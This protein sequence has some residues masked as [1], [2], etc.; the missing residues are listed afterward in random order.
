MRVIFRLIDGIV[1][2]VSEEA[3]PDYSLYIEISSSP[4]HCMHGHF[5]DPLVAAKLIRFVM[6]RELAKER[7]VAALYNLWSFATWTLLKLSGCNKRPYTV[8]TIQ[9]FDYI[10][11]R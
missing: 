3:H 5:G 11:I 9:V 2:L 7:E 6:P 4:L 10:I 1:Y 8:T